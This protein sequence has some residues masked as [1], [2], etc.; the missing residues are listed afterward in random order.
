MYTV[1]SILSVV[2]TTTSTPQITGGINSRRQT[3]LLL[4]YSKRSFLLRQGVVR[5]Q[6]IRWKRR[7]TL[8]QHFK[9]SIVSDSR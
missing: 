3:F 7:G 2:K 1:C 4:G 6:I 9:V 5:Y 8:F